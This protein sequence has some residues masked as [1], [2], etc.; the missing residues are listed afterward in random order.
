MTTPKVTTDTFQ[1]ILL[2][3]RNA[4]V[5]DIPEKLDELDNLLLNME[6]NGA[7]H[8]RFN[9]LYRI[10]HS[11]KGS[12]G[13]HGLHII[14][15][16]CHQ[17]EDLL[18]TTDDGAKFSAQAIESCL[19][20]VDL[21]RVTTGLIENGA[22]EFP[23]IE[24]KLL[25]LHKQ[26]TTQPFRILIVE[27]SKLSTHIYLQTLA[28]LPAQ[29]VAMTDGLLALRRLLNEPFDLLITT[30]E[31]PVLNGIALIGAIRL[32]G[33]KNRNIKSI[34]ITADQKIATKSKRAIDA[35]FVILKDANLAQNLA[36]T[37]NL[38]LNIS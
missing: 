9:A 23:Q 21:L 3:M 32:S 6:K 37:A 27:H 17:M 14:T 24:K 29:T 10:V 15:T 22:I 35:N 26:T 25:A 19:D 11:L 33:S 2:Q 34:L 18:N 7:T 20:Y 38:A 8:E 4:F 12:G 31:N 13:T 28:S 16:I 30:N 1:Q 5:A 36:T